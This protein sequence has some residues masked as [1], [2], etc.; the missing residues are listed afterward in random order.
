MVNCKIE[1]FERKIEAMGDDLANLERRRQM[2]L[3]CKES[4]NAEAHINKF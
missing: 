3:I 2:L 4:Q 1:D